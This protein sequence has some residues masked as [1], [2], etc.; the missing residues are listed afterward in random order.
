MGKIIIK[1][2]SYTGEKFSFE[3]P[4]FKGGLNIIEGKNGNGKSTFMNLIYYGLSGKVEEFSQSNKETHREL[5]QDK[6]NFV[7]LDLK[8]ENAPYSFIRFISSNDITILSSESE[9]RVFPINR[10]KNEKEIF[11]DWMLAKLGIDTIEVYQGT[12]NSKINFKDLLRLIYHNQELNPKKVYKPAD[13]E[14]FISDSELIRKIIFEL[15]VGKTFAEYYSTFAK[16]KEKERDKT[17]AKAILEDYIGSLRSTSS[18]EDLNLI[19]LKKAKTEKEEQLTKLNIYRENLRNQQR[20]KNK[21]YAQINEIKSQILTTELSLNE[22]NKSYNDVI[23]ELSKLRR[24]R[25]NIILEVTQISKIIYSHEKL[26]LFSADTCPYCLREVNRAKGHCVCGS[27]IEEEQ[28]ER[29]FYSSDEYTDILKSKQKS[30]ETIDVAISSCSEEAVS[31]KKEIDQFEAELDE[32][33]YQLTS[34]IDEYDFSSNRQELKQVDDLILGARFEVNALIQKIEIEE[35][36][37]TLQKRFTI[38]NAYYESLRDSVRLLEAKASADIKSKVDEFNLIYNDLI[39]NTLP[40]SRSATIG[41]DDY[42]PIIDGGIYKEASASV[43]IRIMYFF[44]LLKLSL[45][46]TDVNY[47][48]LL[49]IDTPETAGVDSENLK[50]AL[51]QIIKITENHEKDEYQIILTTGID[52]YPEEFKESVLLTLSDEDRLLKPIE[53]KSY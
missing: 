14:N 43:A 50:Q 44:T 24:L 53:Q 33:K 29:F 13:L 6:N 31:F 1:K 19:F 45:N 12:H 25:D 9:A 47:P 21:F 32:F 42:M 10:S 49:L 46:N 4:E 17:I 39:I 23:N 40:H 38:I 41:Y 22:K 26:S 28:Y 51:S 8:I 20:P 5:T 7:R 15:L 36:R 3:S 34:W 52:K 16:F 30:I 48:K 11:S 37:D 18:A 27:D 35:K 2:V